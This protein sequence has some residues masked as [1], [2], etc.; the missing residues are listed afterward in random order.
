MSE[1]IPKGEAALFF[2]NLRPST[3]HRHLT[4]SGPSIGGRLPRVLTVTSCAIQSFP[5][6]LRQ[7]RLFGNKVDVLGF[8]EVRVL[9]IASSEY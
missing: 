2:R 7:S 3:Q 1:V 8:E 4:L 6:E 9:D 5:D